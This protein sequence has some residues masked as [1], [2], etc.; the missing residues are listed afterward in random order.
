MEDTFVRLVKQKQSELG[1]SQS[2]FARRLGFDHSTLSYFY[3]GR[4]SPKVAAAVGL[5]FPDLKN[6]A[7][8][9][10]SDYVPERNTS[11]RS[12]TRKKSPRMTILHEGVLDDLQEE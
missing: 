7:L 2:E 9:F 4:R 5:M 11:E 6:A 10:L 12:A 1:I 3:S 8:L